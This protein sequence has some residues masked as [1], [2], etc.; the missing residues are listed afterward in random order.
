MKQWTRSW[1]KSSAKL[2]EGMQRDKQPWESRVQELSGGRW[3]GLG[4]Q[5]LVWGLRSHKLRSMAP[6]KV[7][8]QGSP[9]SGLKLLDP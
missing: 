1:K 7:R 9:P 8:V 3:L 5:S 4:V 6:P 2:Y